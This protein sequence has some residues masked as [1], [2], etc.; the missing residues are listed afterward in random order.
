MSENEQQEHFQKRI[1]ELESQLSAKKLELETLSF[2]AD[3]EAENRKFFQLIADFTFGWELWF[4]SNGKIKYCSPSCSDMTG[5]TANQIINASGIPELLVYNSDK[6][7]YSEFFV[8]ALNQTLVNQSLEFRILTRTKQIRWCMMSVRGVYDKQGK[9]LGIRASVQ[10]ITRMKSALGH[11]TELEKGKEFEV[12]TA[13]R[14]Q[15]E[16]ELKDREL[17][18]F[19]LQ[20]SQK[21]ELVSQASNLLKKRNQANP[22]SLELTLQQLEILLNGSITQQFDWVMVEAQIEKLYPG[23]LLRLQTKHPGV[24]GNDKKLCS[25]IRLG[26]SSKEIAGLLNIT[27]KSVEVARVRLRKKLQIPPQNRLSYYLLHL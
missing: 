5:F 14:L 15:T 26:L 13:Q 7:K 10:D 20:L 23:F 8:G 4:E 27:P 11:I 6:E 3:R 22:K 1:R 25:Y 18:A 9:Y 16:L 2:Q 12:R 24:S 19:L 21:N 17:V